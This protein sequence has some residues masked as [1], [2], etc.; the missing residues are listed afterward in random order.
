MGGMETD[1]EA[2]P[3]KSEAPAKIVLKLGK[4]R[5]A[6]EEDLSPIVS[7]AEAKIN[8]ACGE[9]LK[10]LGET[11]TETVQAIKKLN[12]DLITK[13]NTDTAKAMNAACDQH[14]AVF[15]KM[16][17]EQT[18]AMAEA[19]DYVSHS[20][21]TASEAS[22]EAIGQ[23]KTMNDAAI[24]NLQKA[25]EGEWQRFAVASSE[26]KE[27]MAAAPK[28]QTQREAGSEAHSESVKQLIL[29]VREM[30]KR[31][32]ASEAAASSLTSHIARVEEVNG[33][34][35]ADLAAAK[36]EIEMLKGTM[37]NGGDDAMEE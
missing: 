2:T 15:E 14:N 32:G 6:A 5:D 29:L 33:Q 4:K 22:S 20:T 23:L 24:A 19:P 35:V 34:L 7:E 9:A 11:R 16:L 25:Y 17:R 27:N 18:E 12:R 8:E 3:K 1:S 26:A 30:D 21:Q 10:V 13:F 31:I 36:Q 28:P 37:V